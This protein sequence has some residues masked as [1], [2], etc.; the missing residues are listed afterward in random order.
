MDPSDIG[1]RIREIRQRRRLTL[2]AT[3]EL[4]GRSHAWLSLIE[5]GMRSLD[6]RSDIDALAAALR[7]SPTELLQQP[8]PPVDQGDA[9]AQEQMEAMRV[10]LVSLDLTDPAEVEWRQPLDHTVLSAQAARAALYRRGEVTATGHALPHLLTTLHAHATN[11]AED[12]QRKALEALVETCC[13]AVSLTK[14]LGYHDLA[15]IGA[16]RGR[17]AAHRLGD[18]IWV[19]LADFYMSYA[20]RPYSLGAANSVRALAAMDPAAGGGPR[21]MQVYGMLQMMAAFGAAV[22]GRDDDMRTHLAEADELAARTGDTSDLELYFGPSNVA[23]WRLTMA[24]ERGEGGRGL[25]AARD[26]HLDVVSRRRRAAY[27]LDLGRAQA[28]ERHDREAVASLLQAEQL[29]PQELH[30]NPFARQII[31]DLYRRARA[32]VGRPDLRGLAAR[33]GVDVS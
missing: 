1:V 2:R 3:A 30:S 22:T 27:L 6:R 15:W 19:G 14:M 31:A 4:A 9:E 11:G 26:V 28:Q 7:V 20:L 12:E 16:E 13:T 29:M 21:A 23:I 32:S 33:V 5:R 18:A 25:E 8:Y 17:Q 10:A 24:V